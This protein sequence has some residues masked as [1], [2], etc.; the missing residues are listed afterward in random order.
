M[1]SSLSKFLCCPRF[2]VLCNTVAVVSLVN[3][4]SMDVNNC[5]YGDIHK[6]LCTSTL[7]GFLQY[8]S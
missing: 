4:G 1:V 5:G 3:S 2:G 7:K 8:H 6:R